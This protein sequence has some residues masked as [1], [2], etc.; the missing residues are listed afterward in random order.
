MNNPTENAPDGMLHAWFS[1]RFVDEYPASYEK[2]NGERIEVTHLSVKPEPYPELEDRV[3]LGLV[4]QVTYE[5]DQRSKRP[6]QINLSGW[7]DD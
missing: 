5:Q 6:L 3:Y 2:E 1:P 4:K 7:I